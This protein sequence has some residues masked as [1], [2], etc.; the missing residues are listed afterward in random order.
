MGNIKKKLIQ[1]YYERT[2]SFNRI[3]NSVA[4]AMLDESETLEQLYEELGYCGGESGK[5]AKEI[6]DLRAA[7]MK[8]DIDAAKAIDSSFTTIEALRQFLEDTNN[9]PISFISN[10][11]K[12]PKR[13]AEYVDVLSDF[14]RNSDIIVKVN[15]GLT[16]L[17]VH[18]A[19]IK[20]SKVKVKDAIQTLLKDNPSILM[21]VVQGD[22]VCVC[23]KVMTVTSN[24]SQKQISELHLFALYKAAVGSIVVPYEILTKP[25]IYFTAGILDPVTYLHLLDNAEAIGKTYNEMLAEFNIYMPNFEEMYKATKLLYITVGDTVTAILPEGDEQVVQMNTNDFNVYLAEVL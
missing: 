17:S 7:Y 10:D 3:Q 1:T 20:Y 11:L 14:Y 21:N 15:D 9:V 13:I 2:G 16:T 5:T 18:L 22:R 19:S 25:Q 6:H 8:S 4:G 24:L 12:P 23:G